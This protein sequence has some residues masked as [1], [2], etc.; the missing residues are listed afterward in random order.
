MI[1]IL[2]LAAVGIV[3][4]AGYMANNWA[5]AHALA[6]AATNG[7]WAVQAEGWSSLWPIMAMGFV[8]GAAIGIGLILVM[9]GRMAAAL[10]AAREEGANEVREQLAQERAKWEKKITSV[11]LESNEYAQ[12]INKQAQFTNEKLQQE[13]EKAL[14][15]ER[16]SRTI[17]GRLKGAQQK[18]ERFKKKAQLTTG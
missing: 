16:K 3:W 2:F 6:V 8:P 17:E 18:A 15:A 7:G 9:G 13:R 10:S 1:F 4:A 11:R 14:R 12:S 5:A